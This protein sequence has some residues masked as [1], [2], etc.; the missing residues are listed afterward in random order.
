MATIITNGK[1]TIR[2]TTTAK[3]AEMLG[4]LPSV[5]L[6][7]GSVWDTKA[8]DNLTADIKAG[9]YVP[10]IVLAGTLDDA[11]I[12]DGQQRTLSISAG[13]KDGR[14]TGE[15]LVYLAIDSGRSVEDAFAVLNIGVPVGAALVSAM[16][17]GGN[18]GSAVVDIAAHPYLSSMRWTHTQDRRTAKADFA[19]AT[20][21]IFAG[22]D[23]PESS[24]KACSSWLASN[25]D[26]VTTDAVMGATACLDAL[27]A[28]T[29]KYVT[30]SVIKG[31]GGKA[32]RAILAQLRKKNLHMTVC[33]A[34]Y[35]GKAVE[36]AVNALQRPDLLVDTKYTGYNATGRK[37]AKTAHWSIGAGSSGSNAE[38]VDR[39]QVL[40]SACDNLHVPAPKTNADTKAAAAVADA[41][42]EDL[43]AALGL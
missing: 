23:S 27:Q 32:A 6:V 26:K 11:T 2:T 5:Q 3:V 37:V 17:I 41:T 42:G 8:A 13:I 20:L 16:E 1:S 28:V 7:R 19:A 4:R 40:L 38:Y 22:W 35:A 21:A 14:L 18:V 31:T 34:V 36:Q 43:A 24:V 9:L 15:E 33:G 10:P 12:V 30:D 25:A 39:L 29:S